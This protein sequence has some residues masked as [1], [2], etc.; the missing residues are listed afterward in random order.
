MP[1]LTARAA[2]EMFPGA[3]TRHAA[4]SRVPLWL[5]TRTRSLWAV[6]G[7]RLYSWSPTLRGWVTWR[8]IGGREWFEGMARDEVR[9]TTSS[10][11]TATA[12]RCATRR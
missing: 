9:P 11:R 6:I 12:P 10:C 3:L 5:T 4:W 7:D 8:Y 1:R 2:R